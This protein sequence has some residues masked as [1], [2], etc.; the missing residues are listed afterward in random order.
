[1][2]SE[3]SSRVLTITANPAIDVTYL[4][5]E[6][7]PGETHRIPAPQHRAGGKG[8]NVARVAHSQGH[9]TFVITTA[10]GDDGTNLRRDLELSG[11]PHRVLP[12]A[13]D[14]RRSI[15]FVDKTTKLTTIFNETGTALRHQEWQ[16]LRDA[17]SE[18]LAG[19]DIGV[20]VGAGSLPPDAPQGFYGDLVCM[21]HS[22]G[23]PAIIDTTGTGLIEAARAGADLL[24]PNH[25]ELME[26]MNDPNLPSAAR[27]LLAAGAKA[28]LVS[29]GA[30]GMYAFTA[31]DPHCYWKARLPQAL[32]GNPTGAGDASVAAA[33]VSFSAG[34]KDLRTV[35]R[36]AAAWGSAAVLMP[37]AGEISSRHRE[38][39]NQLQI[40]TE[41]DLPCP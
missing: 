28:V 1:M 12:V 17:V 30:D 16:E 23:V 21:A 33:A 13:S 31:D 36:A 9:P 40:T 8:I 27:K 20:L 18:C 37:L 38:I 24:K 25:H 22:R 10:G 3:T 14:T 19:R 35:L 32:D 29:A 39:A 4:L 2:T 34:V 26:T 41:K 6:L 7:R 11:I 5:N 15:A